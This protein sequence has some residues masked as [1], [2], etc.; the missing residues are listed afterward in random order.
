[1]RSVV[2][3]TLPLSENHMADKVAMWIKN[4][5]DDITVATEKVV[6]FVRDNCKN[7]L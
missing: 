4:L 7:I 1:M 5:V 2:S 6:A 3:G